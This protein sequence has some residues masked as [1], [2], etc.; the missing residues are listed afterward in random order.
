MARRASWEKEGERAE[1]EREVD[2]LN[3][4]RAGLA[5]PVKCR[6]G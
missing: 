1:R 6:P 4:E 5:M 2:E 3:T